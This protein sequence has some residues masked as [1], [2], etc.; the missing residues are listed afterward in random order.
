MH[1]TQIHDYPRSMCAQKRK[2]AY[3]IFLSDFCI[4]RVHMVVMFHKAQS[5]WKKFQICPLCE[6]TKSEACY[7]AVISSLIMKCE[8]YEIWGAVVGAVIY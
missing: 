4:L 6:K 2:Y 1:K 3:A 5:L 7:I 8:H